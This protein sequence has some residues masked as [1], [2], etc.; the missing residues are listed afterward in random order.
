VCS[1]HVY[2]AGQA[3]AR[4]LACGT[5]EAK[6]TAKGL[7][8]IIPAHKEYIVYK[9]RFC[10]S[11]AVWFCF[12]NTHFCEYCHSHDPWGRAEGKVIDE[13]A[14][15]PPPGK[16]ECPLGL[17]VGSHS[18]GKD[19]SCELS[20]YCGMCRDVTGVHGPARVDASFKPGPA[21][22][23]KIDPAVAAVALNVNAGAIPAPGAPVNA[24]RLMDDLPFLEPDA[25]H[26]E[27]KLPV[28]A[29]VAVVR[30]GAAR[31]AN[32]CLMG[33]C[34]NVVSAAC[35][36]HHCAAHC[37]GPCQKHAKGNPAAR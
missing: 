13:R 14:K 15:C 24:L 34:R 7:V 10:C 28:A 32:A 18:N 9:C 23:M 37:P 21:I 25:G 27:K 33:A 30:A 4:A 1:Q 12:G 3:E 36:T 35:A 8:C 31:P 2:Q 29:P 19:V 26:E 5:C 20:I 17:E 22:K 16:T 6:Q 11:A